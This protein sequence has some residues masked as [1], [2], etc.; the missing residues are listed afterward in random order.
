VGLSGKKVR[1]KVYIALGI[2]GQIQHI[3]G[4]RGSKLVVAVNKDKAAPIFE[5]A[6]YGLVGDLYQIVPKIVE[7]LKA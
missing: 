7:S 4:M 2:S 1:P 5:E 3:A 6:D